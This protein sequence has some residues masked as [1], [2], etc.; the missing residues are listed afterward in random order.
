MEPNP[1]DAIPHI[2]G[3]DT[4][5]LLER[6]G[7]DREL[8][9]EVLG[10]LSAS[11]RDAPAQI[12]DA[13]ERDPALGKQLAHTLKGVLGNLGATALFATCRDLDD[14][15]RE[16]RKECYAQHLAR[17]SADLPALCDAIER[18]RP[19]PGPAS[20]GPAL[21][22]QWLRERYGALRVALD[23]HRARDC[24]ALADEIAATALPAGERTFFDTLQALVRAY[25]FKDAHD[26]LA[27]RLD[28]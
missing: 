15:I 10:E 13:L 22:S 11:Y 8:F 25:R 3:I 21:D 19:A 12:A 23:G 2:P 4:E 5:E 20:A 16:G 18:A 26:L 28:V 17:L 1:S 6:I 7:D 9:W 14:A 24:K 27:R